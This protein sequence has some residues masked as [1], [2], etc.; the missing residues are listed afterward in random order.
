MTII[1]RQSQGRSWNIWLLSAESRLIEI[2]RKLDKAEREP[3]AKC[4]FYFKQLDNPGYAAE[5]Y[6][7]V[8]DLKAL[9]QLHVETHR[10]EEVSVP[11]ISVLRTTTY[12]HW[13]Q[14]KREANVWLP[15]HWSE[16]EAGGEGGRLL[17][18][19]SEYFRYF[20]WLCVPACVWGF[21]ESESKLYLWCYFNFFRR[22]VQ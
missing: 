1:K 13:L 12:C 2:A 14:Q 6:M 22:C 11:L 20:S 17:Q 8:G 5:T 18:K 7:K 16:E 4:A 19:D 10:W 15:Q 21:S 3:L 9:V